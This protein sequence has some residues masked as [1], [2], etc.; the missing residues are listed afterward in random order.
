MTQFLLHCHLFA[1]ATPFGDLLQLA[2]RAGR[3][4]RQEEETMRVSSMSTTVYGGIYLA[5]HAG[6]H[7]STLVDGRVADNAPLLSDGWN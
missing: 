3:A 4:N 2:R 6:P 1:A 5:G 7:R